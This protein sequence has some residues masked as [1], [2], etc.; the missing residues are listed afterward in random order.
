MHGNNSWKYKETGLNKAQTKHF[1]I[2]KGETKCK[3]TQYLA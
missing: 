2:N 1:Q 3:Q